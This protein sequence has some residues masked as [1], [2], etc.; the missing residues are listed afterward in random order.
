[1]AT[2]CANPSGGRIWVS[3][4]HISAMPL[5]PKQIFSR[6]TT[7]VSV[8][9][10]APSTHLQKTLVTTALEQTSTFKST[11]SVSSSDFDDRV[12]Q[13][14]YGIKYTAFCL[15][16]WSLRSFCVI[17][18]HWMG[19]IEHWGLVTHTCVIGSDRGLP[20]ACS[21]PELN[22]NQLQYIEWCS[23]Y[24]QLRDRYEINILFTLLANV[25]STT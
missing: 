6:Y 18:I 25:F 14:L 4:W 21:V 24:P 8:V 13:W 22:D 23:T 7:T 17:Y 2:I 20:P 15:C 11:T 5:Q 16:C 12:D 1:M 9:S 19:Q 3:E 10:P